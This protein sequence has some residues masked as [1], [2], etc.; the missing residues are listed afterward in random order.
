MEAWMINT[1]IGIITIVSSAAIVKHKV[2]TNEK[3]LGKLEDKIDE[4]IIKRLNNHGDD[5]VELITK[6]ELAMT[7]KDVDNKYVSK[8]MFNMFQRHIDKRFDGVEQ[9]LEQILTSVKK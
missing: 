3:N 4:D 2:E 6:S 7:A 8:E 1:I 9:A 5:L